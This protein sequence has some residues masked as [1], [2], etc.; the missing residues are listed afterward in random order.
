M[1]GLELESPGKVLALVQ[2]LLK[3]GILSDWFLFASHKLRISPPLT[4]T[5]EEIE[6]ACFQIRNA[7]DEIYS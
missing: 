3:R 7:L 2:A 4:I 6:V 5:H 1:L